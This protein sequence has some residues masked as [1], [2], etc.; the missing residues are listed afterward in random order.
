MAVVVMGPV[1]NQALPEKAGTTKT[2]AIPAA[3]AGVIPV[4]VLQ[5]NHRRARAVILSIGGAMRFAFN[6]AAKEDFSRMA[7]WPANV[8]YTHLGDDEVWVAADTVAITVSVA[9]GNWAV[10]EDGEH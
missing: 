2:V 4:K 8:P 7:L 6:N 9:T 1:R 5:S 10:G 3:G